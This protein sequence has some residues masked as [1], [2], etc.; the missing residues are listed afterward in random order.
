[1]ANYSFFK[2]N[3]QYEFDYDIELVIAIRRHQKMAI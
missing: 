2:N 3:Q 1:M